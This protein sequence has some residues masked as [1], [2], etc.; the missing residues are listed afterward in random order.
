MTAR[1]VCFWEINARDGKKLAE[2]YRS[3]FG[4]KMD[5]DESNDFHTVH[6]VSEDGK[7]IPGGIFTGKGQLPPHRALYVT[8]TS[9]EDAVDRARDA[10]AKVL[11]ETFDGPNGL[12][13]AFFEDLE[14][15]VIG[16][17]G[18]EAPEE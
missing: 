18:T 13:L 7:G 4:W 14:G 2:F 8:V 11:L 1:P 12:P 3:T 6:S 16:V 10:G 17:V 9:V 15:H 5:Y